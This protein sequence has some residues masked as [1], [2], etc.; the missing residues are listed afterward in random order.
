MEAKAVEKTQAFSKPGSPSHKNLF[1]RVPK[2]G[3]SI[4]EGLRKAQE[5]SSGLILNPK[6]FSW[7]CPSFQGFSEGKLGKVFPFFVPTMHSMLLSL[8][9]LQQA[10]QPSFSCF[11]CFW[12]TVRG[13]PLGQG[14]WMLCWPF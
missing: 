4:P 10:R 1:F 12:C 11:P 14:H 5:I 2:M 6:P 7:K 9:S 13:G 8:L 3:E